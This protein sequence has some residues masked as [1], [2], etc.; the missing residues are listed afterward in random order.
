LEISRQEHLR[1][2]DVTV[3]SGTEVSVQT[4]PPMHYHLDGEPCDDTPLTTVLRP[5]ALRLLVPHTTPDGL[6]RLPGIA[7]S[8]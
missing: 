5:G 1:N 4:R 6:F 3:L 7:L 2:P 8:P